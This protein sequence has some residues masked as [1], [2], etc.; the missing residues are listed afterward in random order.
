MAHLSWHY[1]LAGCDSISNPYTFKSN[2]NHFFFWGGCNLVCVFVAVAVQSFL[3]N[4]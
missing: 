2:Q 4:G 3:F 1:H